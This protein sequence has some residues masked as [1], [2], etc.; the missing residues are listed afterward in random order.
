MYTIFIE[1]MGGNSS[2]SISLLETGT[3]NYMRTYV[4]L[5]NEDGK[6]ETDLNPDEW[7]FDLKEFPATARVM[8][9][10]KPLVVRASD[11]D[12]AVLGYNETE[13]VEGS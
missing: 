10:V 13:S 8:E 12:A 6:V 4:V 7:D 11:P 2:A 3:S 5:R 9:D 1:L